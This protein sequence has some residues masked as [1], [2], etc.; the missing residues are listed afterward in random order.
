LTLREIVTALGLDVLCEGGGLDVPVAGGYSGDLLS[1]VLAAA[2]PGDLWVTTQ[3]HVNVI[4]VAQVAELA[5]VLLA[6]NALPTEAVIAKA[7]E[8]GVVLLGSPH[9]AFELAGRLFRVLRGESR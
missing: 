1:N 2:R 5:G 9:S 3:H 4:G 6:A 8:L 7:D